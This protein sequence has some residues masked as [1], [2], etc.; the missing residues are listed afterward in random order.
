MAEKPREIAVRLLKQHAE[1]GGFIEQIL[2]KGLANTGLSQVDRALAQELMFG[3]VRWQETL[4]WLITQKTRGRT[5][6]TS[7]RILLRLG[8][9]QMFWL[10][11]IPDHAAVHETVELAKRQGFG[12]QSGF[13]NAVLRAYLREREATE[14]SLEELKISK[15][16][17]GYSHPEWLYD[18]WKERFG[19]DNARKLLEWNNTPPAT[20]ARL[21]SLKGAPEGLA[22]LWEEEGVHFFPR[23]FDWLKGELVFEL[24]SH[25][26]LATLPSFQGGWFYIQD[27]STLLAPTLLAPQASER[28]VDMCAAPGGKTTFMAQLMENRG[29]IVARE[30]HFARREMVRRNCER[31]GVTCVQISTEPANPSQ[32]ELFDRVLIDAPCSNSG[33]V[34]RRVDLRWRIDPEE[35]ARLRQTQEQL[36]QE[37]ARQL[38][39]GGTLV[40]S[41]CSLELEENQG[42]IQPFLAAEPS[43]KLEQERSL[44]PFEHAVDGAYVALLSK[45][46]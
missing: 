28:I 43:F 13:I 33:V 29:L 27:P 15:P 12:A 2:E 18:R 35:I 31:L 9:Y 42:V 21:N 7:L 23:Q 46:L 38:R 8:L 19:D 17:L 44:L 3:V 37:G 24:K 14:Q 36:L 39:K 25:P 1:E 40:Y 30:P 11:R 16:A 4:D 10:E 34:R 6:K 26:P 22:K 5:Q 41:T 45:A 20:F 32:Q